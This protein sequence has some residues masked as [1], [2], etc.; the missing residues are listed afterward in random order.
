MSGCIVFALYETEIVAAKIQIVFPRYLTQ[1]NQTHVSLCEIKPTKRKTNQVH[2][3]NNNS[4][5]IDVLAFLTVMIHKSV[6]KEM[7][8]E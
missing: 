5:H 4:I 6:F 7:V 8:F 1:Q 3:H 2:R